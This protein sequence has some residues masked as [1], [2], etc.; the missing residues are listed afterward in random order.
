M[1]RDYYEILGVPKTASEDD[2]KKAYR[3]L[4]RKYHPDLNKD[5][6]EEA[7][8]K[9]KE[10]NEAYETLSD[11]NKRAQYDQFGH[12]AY[13]QAGQG[14]GFG[15]QGAYSGF[16]NF[17]GFG[18]IFEQFFGG[19]GTSRRNGPIDGAD[20]RYDLEITLEEAAFGATKEFSVVREETCPRC[21]GNGAEPGTSVTE[22]PHCHGT[23]QEQVVRN[24]PFGQMAT[25]VTCSHCGGTG[26]RIETPC[27]ECRGTGVVRKRRKLEVNI[28]A[29]AD[30]NTRIRL[31]G[32][33]E[34]GRRGGAQGDLYVYVYVKPHAKFQRRG[35]DLFCVQPISFPTAALG[36][37][38]LVET[39]YG[40]LELK[41]PHGTQGGKVFR[42]RE[43]GMTDFRSGRK[44]DLHVTIHIEVPQSLNDEQ[45]KALAQYADAMGDATVK[46]DSSFFS[47]L[48]DTF[49]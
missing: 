7:E 29:G 28:P 17:G 33:G 27:K 11:S 2:L 8:Q 14:G 4:A 38:V 19:G 49:C 15:G 21:H 12:D 24:T 35:A 41:I 44:G 1:S 16:S 22:C 46:K 6:P 13:K 32:E 20:L 18:D 26:K 39:L 34:P 45:R 23:G 5:K 47:K 43:Q 9:F 36:G 40:K 10:V 48:K 31:A 30:T 37:E 42:L 3:K 25:V